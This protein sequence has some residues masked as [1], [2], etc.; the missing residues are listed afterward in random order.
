MD[1]LVT[2]RLTLRPPLE[3]D[4]DDI[5]EFIGNK[6]VSRMLARV[7]H[8]YFRKDAED[9]ISHV[10]RSIDAGQDLT[11]TIHRER[12]IGV[13]SLEGFDSGVPE[14]GYW[15]A[16]PAWGKGFATEAGAAVL[17]HVFRTRDVD[18]IASAVFKENTASLN[19]Q[20]K[21]GFK[22]TGNGA[23]WSNARSEMV[24]DFKTELTRRDFVAAGH[25]LGA[26]PSPLRGGGGEEG[27]EMKK[28]SRGH[29]LQAQHFPNHPHP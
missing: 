5:A 29:I 8:P 10:S 23:L 11:F 26:F 2:K 1:I 18:R 25:S 17:S 14:F 20:K 6:N 15:L 3:V 12:L 16:E 21:L 28:R 9:W 24:E 22:L 27:A 13:M 7:P 19:V 4:I